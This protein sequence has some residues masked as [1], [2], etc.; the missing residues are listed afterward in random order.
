MDILYILLV[1]RIGPLDKY[2]VL[3]GFQKW[4]LSSYKFVYLLAG[5]MEFYFFHNTNFCV[6]YSGL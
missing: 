3:K 6:M 4:N 5:E 1:S 2:W